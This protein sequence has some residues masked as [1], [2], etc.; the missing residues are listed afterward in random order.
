VPTQARIIAGPRDTSWDAYIRRLVDERGYGH[1]REYFG[2]TTRE[3]ADEV[4]RKLRTAGRHLGVSVR[5]FWRECTGCAAGGDDCAYHVHYAVFHPEMA[6]QYK[7][8][9]A[10]R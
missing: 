5:A 2:C 3:R 6:R 9:Q 10:R 7:A 1:E 4:R 8:R